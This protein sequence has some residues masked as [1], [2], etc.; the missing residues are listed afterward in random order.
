MVIIVAGRRVD[1]ADAKPERFPLRNADDVAEAIARRLEAL[2]PEALVCSAACGADL[3]ALE[4][5]QS[6]GIRRRIVLPFEPERFRSTSV[7]DRP[8]NSRW[9]WGRIYDDQIR[10]AKEKGDLVVIPPEED[11]TAAYVAANKH[12]IIEAEKLAAEKNDSSPVDKSEEDRLR[13]LIIWEGQSRGDDDITA[14]LI[15]RASSVGA[16]VLQVNTLQPS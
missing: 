6:S 15:E 7:V 10:D 16:E 4:T 14:E 1:A 8:G 9:D 5:A 3:I 12:I 11:E 2:R 13:C